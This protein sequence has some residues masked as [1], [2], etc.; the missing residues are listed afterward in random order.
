MIGWEVG[1]GARCGVGGEEGV[2]LVRSMNFCVLERE[3]ILSHEKLL[4]I[5]LGEFVDEILSISCFFSNLPGALR[6][7]THAH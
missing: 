7:F 4:T 6:G 3:F 5:L 1:A 2:P